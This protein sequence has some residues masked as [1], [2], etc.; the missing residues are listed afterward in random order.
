[1]P[2]GARLTYLT[3]GTHLQPGNNSLLL[4]TDIQRWPPHAKFHNGQTMSMGVVLSVATLY[5][6]WR[7]ATPPT[8]Q[9]AV[10]SLSPNTI[11]PASASALPDRHSID[12]ARL[13]EDSIF[14]AALFGTVYWVTGLSAYFFPGSL[15][16]DPEFGEGFPQGPLFVVLG[17]AP[18]VGW[19]CERRRLRHQT[20]QLNTV[21]D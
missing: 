19:W 14:T 1:M 18:W 8:T 9:P 13:T 20:I 4:D 7:Y 10:S 2:I 15:A 3:R 17:I 5:Y 21:R 12:Q 16:I 11:K 6:T